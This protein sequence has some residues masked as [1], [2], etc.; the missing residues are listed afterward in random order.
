MT[1]PLNTRRAIARVDTRH[2]WSRCTIHRTRKNGYW[3]LFFVVTNLPQYTHNVV[4]N[5]T[6]EPVLDCSFQH[7]SKK[8]TFTFTDSLS[9]KTL[10]SISPLEFEPTLFIIFN[11]I[12]YQ[13]LSQTLHSSFDTIP[14]NV[15]QRSVTSYNVTKRL[16]MQWNFLQRSITFYN[17]A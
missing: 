14:N 17:V 6:K 2:K 4:G 12:T 1:S 3:M 13:V 9:L 8:F 7:F 16:I 15:L 5:Q 11:P 10:N